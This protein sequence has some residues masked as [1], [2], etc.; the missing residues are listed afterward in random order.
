[1]TF[2]ILQDEVYDL[3]RDPQKTKYTLVTVKRRINEATKFFC[4]A[5]Y[6]TECSDMSDDGDEPP[7][8][9]QFHMGIA[10]LAAHYCARAG[11]DARVNE[12]YDDFVKIAQQA[13]IHDIDDHYGDEWAVIGH[14]DKIGTFEPT[15][16][17]LY[18]G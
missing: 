12:F 14:D 9:D 18:Y 16:K 2:T 4:A 10:F 8:S 5:I 6:N 13:G 3:L 11:D 17:D 15:D 7:I 1:M